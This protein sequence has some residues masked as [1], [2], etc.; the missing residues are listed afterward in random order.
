LRLS[1]QQISYWSPQGSQRWLLLHPPLSQVFPAQQAWPGPPQLGSSQIVPFP[2]QAIPVSQLWLQHTPFVELQM[3]L[4]Q[5]LGSS[6]LAP[7]ARL[8]T[9]RPP[10]QC[11]PLVQTSPAQQACPGSPQVG[12]AHVNSAPLQATPVAQLSPQ[13]KPLVE[14]QIPLM[15]SLFSS[16]RSPFSRS[17]WQTPPSQWALPMQWLSSSHLVRQAVAPQM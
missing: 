5:S 15:Q 7:L 9:Q 14:L 3:P 10:S 4:M 11:A 1:K 12:A 6:Q 17:P 16:Q 2:T 8:A 13:Q